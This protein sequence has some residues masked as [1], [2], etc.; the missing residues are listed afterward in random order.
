VKAIGA[1]AHV[2]RLDH[3]VEVDRAGA[4]LEGV[5]AKSRA[6]VN[7]RSAQVVCRR[8]VENLAPARPRDRVL[9]CRA[10]LIEADQKILA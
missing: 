6:E 4:G 2:E 7:Q 1:R 9:D 10:G 5:R 3:A 8:R